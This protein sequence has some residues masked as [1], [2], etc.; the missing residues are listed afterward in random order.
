VTATD[1]T[2]SE[3]PHLTHAS[4]I[5]SEPVI[6]PLRRFRPGRTEQNQ[7]HGVS[8]KTLC[9]VILLSFVLSHGVACAQDTIPPYD[10]YQR[11][12]I[13]SLRHAFGV[14]M[15]GLLSAG[16]LAD[17]YFTWWKDVAKPF[18][19]YTEGWF[20]DA[21]K[22]IDKLG[23]FYGSHATFK[24]TREFLLYSGSSPEAALW[25][26]AGIAA[27]HSLEIEIGDGFS[28]WGFCYEDLVMGWLGIAYGMLQAEVPYFRNFS[29]K[30]S[31]WSNAIKS[32]ANFTNDYDAMTVWLAF[33]VHN[34]LPSSMSDY[35]PKFLRLAVGYGLGYGETRRELAIGFDINLDAI[36]PCSDEM[37]LGQRV[38]NTLRLPLPTV[39]FTEG[40]GPVWYMAH[41][42]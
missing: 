33:D 22:G 6:A 1:P 17:S 35:W 32:P 27:F 36:T 8:A 4:S 9:I 41:L 34:L 15:V 3:T 19:F 38:L 25:W 29:F 2:T 14:G 42:K 21:Y 40:K 20:S 13:S 11:G 39:K 24:L 31:Y 10:G 26:S 5:T 18:S 7:G 37:L 30:F 23:H 28:P 12:Q 16:I